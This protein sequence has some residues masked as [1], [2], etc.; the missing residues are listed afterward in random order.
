[1]V[2][3][4]S[5]GCG[6]RPF[7]P[8]W[9]RRDAEKP[10][11]PGLSTRQDRLSPPRRP[12][13]PGGHP[14]RRGGGGVGATNIALTKL[15]ILSYMA[16]IPVCAAYEIDG[17]IT[18]EFPFPAVLEQA[19]PVMEYRPGWQCDISGARTWEEELPQAA[20]DYVAYVKRPSA[21]TSATSPW[22]P[23]AGELDCPVAILRAFERCT[24]VLNHASKTQRM[25]RHSRQYRML[26]Y[27]TAYFSNAPRTAKVP[28]RLAKPRQESAH[29]MPCTHLPPLPRVRGTC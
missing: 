11:R 27:A 5:S 24:F 26:K 29:A 9:V 19:K 7:T 1:M 21:A 28:K 12:H 22:A 20:R 25:L 16:E 6:R 14:L 3:A 10:V 15:D 17:L 13:R 18:H 23:R 2:K 4:Y 8:E